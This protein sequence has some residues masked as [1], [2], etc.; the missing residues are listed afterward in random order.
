[1]HDP[2]LACRPLSSR[3]KDLPDYMADV[4]SYLALAI[5]PRLERNR[6][7]ILS[8]GETLKLR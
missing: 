4:Q 5:I 3:A 6:Q 8:T 1:M 2:F 7:V